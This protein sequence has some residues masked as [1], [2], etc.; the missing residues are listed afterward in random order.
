MQMRNTCELVVGLAVCCLLGSVGL[1]ARAGGFPAH[2]VILYSHIDVI[3]FNANSGN[4][5][6]GYVSPSGREYALMGLSNKVAFVEITDPSNPDWFATVLHDDSLWGD[7]KV[8]QDVA[9]VVVDVYHSVGIQ[10]IDMS[11]I[12]N[13]N[14]TLVR[15]ICCPTQNHNIV[16]DADSG[17]LYTCGS[18]GGSDRTVI[19]DL[20]DPLDPVEVGTWGTYEH[21]A[22]V[23]TYTSGPYAGRQI[24]FGASEGRG[25]DIIDV[26]NKSNTF[27]I[28]R[29]PYPNVAYCHQVWTE[30][31]HY[32]YVDDEL[33]GLS[34]TRVFDITSLEFPVYLG[35]IDYRTN[36]IDHNLYVRD[37]FI[38]EANYHS[39]LRVFNANIDPV[40]PPQVAWFDTYPENDGDGF[41]G[42]WSCYPYF[43]SGT[44]LV[45]DIDRGLFVLG[46][47]L[48]ALSFSYPL[49][50]PGT[51]WPETP[52]PITVHIDATGASLDPTTVTLH[53]RV[54]GGAET[55]V[56][57]SAQGNDDF[58]GSLPG[59]GCFSTITFHVSAENTLGTPFVDPPGAP[60]EV[61]STE[62]LT[63][64][65]LVFDDD[66]ETDR[67]WTVGAG[68][69][70]AT[71]GIWV[72]VDPNGTSAQ[73][74]DDHTPDPGTM[75][76]V[77]GQGPVGGDIGVNDVDGGR[78]TLLSPSI[79]LSAG[80]ARVGYWRWY[81]NDVGSP[82]FTD[83]F[84]ID[85]S[86]NNGASWTNV[87]T[88]GPT[89]PGTSGG[90][91][92]HEFTVSDF[93]AP[94]AQ[95]MMRFIASDEG[96]GSI[97]EAAIDDFAVFVPVC[98]T[99]D[100]PTVSEWG[101][102]ATAA[103]LLGAGAVLIKRSRRA[104]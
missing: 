83:T 38:Y 7:V 42:A 76:F 71:T 72:R 10:V 55:T 33:D 21:D 12:D 56:A 30:D 11:D 18:S 46:V 61:Y 101:L 14:V 19:F 66:M 70:D 47:D 29:T 57:M 32:L 59:A 84:L 1:E 22:Q 51:V 31:L 8:Y 15:T 91:I 81:S 13:G 80:D 94:T 23:I 62:V 36:S 102:A 20:S 6:W 17:Y 75:C 68:G 65:D 85:I 60:A 34:W 9:Y 45:S 100:I 44:V 103:L 89:G 40:N 35:Y 104:A 49:G 26:T 58:E 95:V 24:M 67:G 90:W 99:G 64:F 88:I 25:L 28:S 79:D 53:A 41:D 93:V 5:C 50:L 39:G 87:E 4:D 86:N 69:D 92:Y 77:T 52:T 63:G 16:V 96:G 3:E 43:P 82:P 2:N 98:Q 74:E 54:D 97:V 27:L 73:P 48:N 78:T 37:G